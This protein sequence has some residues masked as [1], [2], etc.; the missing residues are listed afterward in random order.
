[1]C[2]CRCRD[3]AGCWFSPA[4]DSFI[5][6][7]SCHSYRLLMLGMETFN[8]FHFGTLEVTGS[9]AIKA[10]AEHLDEKCSVSAECTVAGRGVGTAFGYLRCIRAGEMR[11]SVYTASQTIGTTASRSEAPMRL[12]RTAACMRSTAD[13]M[14]LVTGIIHEPTIHAGRFVS[15]WSWLEC[16]AS[17]SKWHEFQGSEL[18]I[19]EI[20]AWALEIRCW[21]LAA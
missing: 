17:T 16:P 5:S 9:M 3:D 21:I 7:S 10:S 12:A 1:M 6:R 14:R 2:P 8:Q 15:P 4:N 19:V 18:L 13:R 11:V 20:W